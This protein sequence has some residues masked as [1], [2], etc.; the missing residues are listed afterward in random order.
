V[1]ITFSLSVKPALIRHLPSSLTAT[2]LKADYRAGVKDFYRLLAAQTTSLLGD[3]IAAFAM[4]STVVFRMHGSAGDAAGVF[5][6]ALL[7]TALLGPVAGVFADRW[8]P[9]RTMIASDLARSALVLPLAF[10]WTLPQL[11]AISFAVSCCSAFF[12]PARTVVI[13]RIVEAARL[14][15]ANARIQQV[16]QL[17]RVASPAVAGALVMWAG[18][19]LCYFADSASFVISASLICRLSRA[20]PMRAQ[21]RRVSAMFRELREGAYFL[22]A[23]PQFAFAMVAGAFATGCFGALLPVYVRDV[24]HGAPATYAALGTSVAAGSLAGAFIM[25]GAL[26]LTLMRV[27]MIAI[28]LPILSMAVVTNSAA[29]VA[30]S[31]GIGLGAAWVAVALGALLQGSTPAALR[32]RVSAALTSLM[33]AAQAAAL[34]GAGALAAWVGIPVA[35]ACCAALLIVGCARWIMPRCVR[36]L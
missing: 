20:A 7:P 14:V 15:E 8:D 33:A 13:P 30:A 28:G 24:L 29:A 4:Q 23:D 35:F 3:L 9:R 16:T 26:P 32:G 2:V 22:G 27:G 31:F 36:I 18:E 11:Y 12:A 6:A 25:P 17:V 1:T 10:A 19:W 5:L 34:A 21:P